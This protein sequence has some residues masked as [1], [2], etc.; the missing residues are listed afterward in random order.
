[1]EFI[2]YGLPLLTALAVGLL[3]RTRRIGFWGAI[4]VSIFLT[5]VGGFLVAMIS[6]AKPIND[7]KDEPAGKPLP[8]RTPEEKKR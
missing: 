4:I 8:K 1:M 2:K 3:G 6:G 7:E 5:P